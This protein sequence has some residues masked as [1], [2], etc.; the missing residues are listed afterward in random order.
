MNKAGLPNPL[1]AAR[2]CCLLEDELAELGFSLL[3][4]EDMAALHEAKK[5]SRNSVV[6]PMH[7]HK[8]AVLDEGRAYWMQLTEVETG[9][10]IGIQAYRC[11]RV[12]THLADWCMNYMIGVYMRRQELMVPSHINPPGGSVSL[13]LKGNLVYH[14][15][16]WISPTVKNRKVMESFVRLGTVLSHIKWNPEAIWALVSGQVA[17]NGF[18]VRSGYVTVERGFLRWTWASDGIDPTEYLITLERDSVLALI[19]NYLAKED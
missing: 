3:V 4:S 13:R 7:D 16:C 12:D 19:E 17:R 1:G 10:I 2:M 14:G 15:E 11:D 8:V 6:G 9:N 18:H 5:L